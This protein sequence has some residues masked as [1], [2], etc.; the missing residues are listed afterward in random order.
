MQ[1]SRPH[2]TCHLKAYSPFKTE[3]VLS[4]Q[5]EGVLS[6][7]NY[8][9]LTSC[10]CTLCN[11]VASS[12]WQ[13][14]GRPFVTTSSSF[15]ASPSCPFQI[16]SATHLNYCNPFRPSCLPLLPSCQFSPATSLFAAVPFSCCSPSLSRSPDQTLSPSPSCTCLLPPWICLDIAFKTRTLY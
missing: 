11:K 4:F 7:Q 2:R 14:H 9:A 5:K 12:S 1:T 13:Q 3:G 10:R 16:T 15:T 6:F 8:L